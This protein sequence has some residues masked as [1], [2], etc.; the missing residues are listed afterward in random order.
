MSTPT[1]RTLLQIPRQVRKGEAFEVR[2]TIGHPMETGY[3]P[4]VD[5]RI[6][7]RDI[8]RR[9]VCRAGDQV[10]FDADFHPALAANPYLSF[11]LRLDASTRLTLRWDGDNGFSH[12][13]SVDIAVLAG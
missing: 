12:S 10:V 2:V 7:P 1:V 3:R 9:F 4:G 5:G 6:V 13:E 8:I 11:F